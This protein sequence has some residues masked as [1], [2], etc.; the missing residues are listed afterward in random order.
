M[1]YRICIAHCRDY[2]LDNEQ[3]K[4]VFE[5]KNYSRLTLAKF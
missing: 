1:R 5:I 4:V 3:E 2:R